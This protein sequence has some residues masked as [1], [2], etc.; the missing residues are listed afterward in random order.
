V[1]H[2]VAVWQAQAAVEL[3]LRVRLLQLLEQ[4]ILAAAVAAELYHK[5]AQQA[6]QELSFFV[7]QL[8]TQLLSVVDL[9]VQQ[10]PMDHSKLQQLLLA[11][12]M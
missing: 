12:E 5:T 10:Q 6:V 4:L 9:L 8:L 7:T 1:L 11:Q 3:A 2:Q